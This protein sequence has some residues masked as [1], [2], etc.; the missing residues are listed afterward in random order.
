MFAE[1]YNVFIS[2]GIQI[3][4]NQD[5]NGFCSVS[6]SSPIITEIELDEDGL[7]GHWMQRQIYDGRKLDRYVSIEKND[8]VCEITQ[9]IIWTFN[10]VKTEDH[11]MISC[12]EFEKVK[13]DALSSEK[14][15]GGR[16]YRASMGI[17][18]SY[19]N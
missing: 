18:Y 2:Q 16:D 7:G 6:Q 15:F 12:E 8:S 13:F 14:S 17:Y 1:S 9:N 19:N 10:G 3:C 11:S 5:D 4:S